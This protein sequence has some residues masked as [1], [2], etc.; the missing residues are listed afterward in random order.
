MARRYF[1]RRLGTG[2]VF[3]R[4]HMDAYLWKNY[5]ADI[6]KSDV[7]YYCFWASVHIIFASLYVISDLSSK[8]CHTSYIVTK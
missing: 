5:H 6:S 8:P 1:L 7:L 4:Q 3:Y 2:A